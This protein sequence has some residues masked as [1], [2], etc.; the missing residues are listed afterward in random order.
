MTLKECAEMGDSCGLDD[1]T[2]AYFNIKYH[3]ISIFEYERI[4]DE[5]KELVD[6]INKLTQ[7]GKITSK[8]LIKDYLNSLER[9]L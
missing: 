5:M 2:E 6:E 8:T 7:E 4:T 1:I 3:A 9:K